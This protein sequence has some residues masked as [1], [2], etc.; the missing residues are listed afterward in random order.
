[1]GS[2]DTGLWLTR[3]KW[4]ALITHL[5][6]PRLSRNHVGRILM[7]DPY[8]VAMRYADRIGTGANLVSSYFPWGEIEQIME[9]PPLPDAGEMY[10]M[11]SEEGAGDG[12]S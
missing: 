10:W 5:R 8:G 1:M 3:G 11:V 9:V 2:D 4:V 6:D 7:A 12:E